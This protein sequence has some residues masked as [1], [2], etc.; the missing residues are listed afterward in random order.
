MK[1]F[2]L[3]VLIVLLFLAAALLGAANVQGLLVMGGGTISA[4]ITES[5]GKVPEPLFLILFGSGLI[6]YSLVTRIKSKKRIRTP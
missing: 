4:D 5:T 2:T 6:G 1:K 3:I